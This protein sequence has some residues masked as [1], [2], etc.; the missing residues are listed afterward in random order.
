MSLPPPGGAADGEPGV[1]RAEGAD[2]AAPR[3]SEATARQH[4]RVAQHAPLLLLTPPP[5]LPAQDAAPTLKGEDGQWAVR[6][7][8]ERG[9]RGRGKW[10][11]V[12]GGEVGGL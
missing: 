7:D 9:G 3:G 2:P 10:E 11:R 6:E 8:G 12:G 5:P 4:R 1:A